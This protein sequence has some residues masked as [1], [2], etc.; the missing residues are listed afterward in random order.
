MSTAWRF[1]YRYTHA[2]G[3]SVALAVANS[4]QGW[5]WSGRDGLQLG[6]IPPVRDFRPADRLARLAF[7]RLGVGIVG[8][9]LPPF[10]FAHNLTRLA[11]ALRTLPTE[12]G[13][14]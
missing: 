11:P 1:R 10:A 13:F 9:C 6:S 3:V 14:A 2:T 8:R 5:V 7:F 4:A 12:T